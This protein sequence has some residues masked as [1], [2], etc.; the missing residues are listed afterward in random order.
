MGTTPAS[1]SA[2]PIVNDAAAAMARTDDSNVELRS[3]VRKEDEESVRRFLELLD[4]EQP[5]RETIHE[6]FYSFQRISPGWT[7]YERV[8]T[9]LVL[10][11]LVPF[12]LIFLLLAGSILL[13]IGKL[14]LISSSS[15]TKQR[16]N[17]AVNGNDESESDDE[18]LYQPLSKWRRLLLSL[19]SP[20]I[21]SILF[22]TFGIYHIR[23][24]EQTEFSSEYYNAERDKTVK[25]AYV[26]VANHLG[27]IDI[28]VLM[29]SFRGSFVAKGECERT[30]VVG[31]LARALQCMFVHEGQSLTNQ[32]VRRVKTTWDCHQIREQQKRC[33]DAG[34]MTCMTSLVI[35][36]EGTTTNGFSMIPFRTGVFNA[37]VALKPI[38]IQFPH[39]HFNLSWE[40]I[41]FRDHVFRTLT[42][43]VNNVEFTELP[44]Y[45][46][47]AQEV[48]NTKLFSRNVQFEMGLALNQRVVPLNRKMK[49]LYHSYLLGKVENETEVLK[50]A[51]EL[52]EQDE[53]LMDY[54]CFILP[55]YKL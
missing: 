23:H 8:K 51:K 17:D 12:R 9:A 15:P 3:G 11:F 4:T 45:V 32:L 33:G 53:L 54:I 30:P 27:Y 38:C 48:E 52:L 5:T 24:K 39:K 26:I 16:N 34:C 10:I 2:T 18:L 25:R 44:V 19:S 36:P 43:V 13:L 6:L 49:F 35:F 40:T 20:L 41:R 55:D 47:S 21:R 7:F 28:L 37:G 50:K 42:Q 14:A 29:Y 1:T 22:V 46:P 31:I